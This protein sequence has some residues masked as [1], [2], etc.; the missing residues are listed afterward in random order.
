MALVAISKLY[1]PGREEGRE[2]AEV[3]PELNR[4]LFRL[5]SWG[6]EAIAIIRS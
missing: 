6:G 4:S 3:D 5:I 1:E 2:S